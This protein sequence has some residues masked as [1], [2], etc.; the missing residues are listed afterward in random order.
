M[1]IITLIFLFTSLNV[2]TEEVN[3]PLEDLNRKTYEFNEKLDSTILKPTAELYSK[4]PPK[5][6]QGVTNF[7]NN[8]EEIDTSVN[9]LLQGKPKKSLNDF[10]RFVI[11]LTL[12]RCEFPGKYLKHT[13]IIFLKKRFSVNRVKTPI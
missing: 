9:Q 10:T 3:D 7:F 11:K 8:L 6:K 2:H 1:R 5:V 13:A 4:F 12:L